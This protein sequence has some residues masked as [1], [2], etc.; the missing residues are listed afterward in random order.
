MLAVDSV[1]DFESHA[2]RL[3]STAV[4]GQ[5]LVHTMQLH[6]VQHIV[7]QQ[8]SEPWADTG[9]VSHCGLKKDAERAQYFLA[10]MLASKEVKQMNNQKALPHLVVVSQAQQ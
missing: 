7:T 2:I 3:L 5:L 4:E 9:V 8:V 10:A 1:K 6:L